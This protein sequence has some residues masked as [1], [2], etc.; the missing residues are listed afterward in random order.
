M[1]RLYN[2][3]LKLAYAETL[4]CCSF[5]SFF[6]ISNLAPCAAILAASAPN[7]STG[8]GGCGGLTK[9]RFRMATTNLPGYSPNSLPTKLVIS[10]VVLMYWSVFLSDDRS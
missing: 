10:F 3:A 2:Q 4:L 9:A 7:A 6:H 8:A 1:T 5:N